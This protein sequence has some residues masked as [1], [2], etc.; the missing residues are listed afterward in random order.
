MLGSAHDT[1]IASYVSPPKASQLKPSVA[2]SH[3]NTLTS[4]LPQASKPVTTSVSSPS[5]SV[6]KHQT[7]SSTSSTATS[8]STTTAPRDLDANPVSL[9]ATHTDPSV[10]IVQLAE[11]P[12]PPTSTAT[13]TLTPALLPSVSSKRTSKPSRRGLL[14]NTCVTRG[15]LCALKALSEIFPGKTFEKIRPDW[16]IN[17]RTSRALE[18]DLYNEELR[19]GAEPFCVPE[20]PPQK[21]ARVRRNGLS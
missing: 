20:F 2:G 6:A 14:G 19:L 11:T 17:D 10:S 5:T 1:N 15:E 3:V 21:S 7:L 12:S 8:T 4:T 13:V 16:L 18:I 9:T